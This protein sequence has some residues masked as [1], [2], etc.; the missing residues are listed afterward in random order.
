MNVLALG[1]LILSSLVTSS[2]V[3]SPTQEKRNSGEDHVIVKEGHRIVVVEFEKDTGNTKISISPHATN[4]QVDHENAKEKLMSGTSMENSREKLMKEDGIHRGFRPKELV[5][6]AY[7]KCKR[8]IESV[9]AKANEGVAVKVHEAED[10]GYEVEEESREA[11]SEAVGKVKD[12]A[13]KA[14][15]KARE[16]EE[17]TKDA[18]S[19][20]MS[21]AKDMLGEKAG[22]AKQGAKETVENATKR[23]KKGA[24]GVKEEGKK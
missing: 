20:A 12:A 13:Y 4:D 17:G 3:L 5:C 8:K 18:A 23:V 10:I 22:G 7:G 16:A 15:D 6:N 19:E 9:M 24:P 14:Y 11:A 21:K 1:L 2:G